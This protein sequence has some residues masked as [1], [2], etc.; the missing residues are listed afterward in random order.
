MIEKTLSR[1]EFNQAIES[2]PQR[3]IASL[4][5]DHF[6]AKGRF[7]GWRI[8]GFA[9]NSGLA[10]SQSILAGDII[11][12]VNDEPLERPEQFMRAWEV[13]RNAT[14]LRVTLIR[15]KSRLVYRWKI[16]P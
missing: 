3:F 5:L 8:R 1:L 16:Q 14:E 6:M 12:A 15:G 4:H 11:V 7:L 10:N 13:A 2:G 9:P